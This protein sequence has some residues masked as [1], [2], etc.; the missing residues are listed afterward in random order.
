MNVLYGDYDLEKYFQTVAYDGLIEDRCPE[1]WW[2]RMIGTA[3]FAK[4][5]GFDAFTT[6][7]LASPYQDQDVIKSI[8]E[9][10]A[11]RCE[12]KFYSEDFR[13]GF[14]AAHEKA[15]AMGMYCQSYC[16]CVFSEKERIEEKEQKKQ[17]KAKK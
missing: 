2:L 7:L 13:P 4:E 10:V 9:D 5:N 11:A 8:G 14:K 15:R 3:K 17:G 1:C 16:G 6:T 12:L